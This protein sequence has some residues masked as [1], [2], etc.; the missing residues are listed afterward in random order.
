MLEAVNILDYVQKG[1]FGTKI[2]IRFYHD[3]PLTHKYLAVVYKEASP[4]D[5][6]IITAYFTTAPAKWREVLWR[7]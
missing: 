2:A 4:S 5:G 1:D 7:R 3:T 6:F